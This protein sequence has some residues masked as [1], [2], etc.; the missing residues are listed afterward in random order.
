[1][2]KKGVIGL[3]DTDRK[4]ETMEDMDHAYLDEKSACTWTQLGARR[5][6]TR[7]PNSVVEG[8]GQI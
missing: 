3:M 7:R 1:M 5:D 6:A 8:M 4:V 2:S